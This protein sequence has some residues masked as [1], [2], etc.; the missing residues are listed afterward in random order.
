MA[1]LEREGAWYVCFPTNL[2]LVAALGDAF[3]ALISSSFLL[4]D[5]SRTRAHTSLSL[6]LFPFFVLFPGDPLIPAL[7]TRLSLTRILL[8]LQKYAFAIELLRGIREEDEEE[9]EA[10]YLEG[11][12][13][14]LWGEEVALLGSAE[15][16]AADGEKKE[17]RPAGVDVGEGDEVPEKKECWEEA[18]ESLSVCEVVSRFS[19]HFYSPFRLSSS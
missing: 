7:P 6:S 12:A 8:E 9:V 14:F 13:W 10:A 5:A 2:S 15:G 16:G 19:L 3:L 1:G 18:R 11:W 4:D 17:S